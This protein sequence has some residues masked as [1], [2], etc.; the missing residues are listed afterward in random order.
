MA[1]SKGSQSLHLENYRVGGP[2]NNFPTDL[3]DK[4]KYKNQSHNRPQNRSQSQS[5][6][7]TVIS[8]NQSKVN[9]L[10][11]TQPDYQRV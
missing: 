8:G 11:V 3:K 9:D 1:V 10:G 2:Q 5:H 6:S 7:A 4:K